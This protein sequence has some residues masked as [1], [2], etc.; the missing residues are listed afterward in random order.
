[1]G[2]GVVRGER[3]WRGQGKKEYLCVRFL[4]IGD[5]VRPAE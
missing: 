4:L 1:M 2:I 3:R 5:D